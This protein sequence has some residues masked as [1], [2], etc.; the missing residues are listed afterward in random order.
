MFAA[1]SIRKDAQKFLLVTAAR[2]K[3]GYVD[4]IGIVNALP[5]H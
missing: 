5:V 3:S 2:I 1:V 4:L